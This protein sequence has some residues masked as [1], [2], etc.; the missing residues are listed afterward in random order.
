V[1]AVFAEQTQLAL[2]GIFF[3]G[4]YDREQSHRGSLTGVNRR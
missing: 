1:T 4:R 2:E 3:E